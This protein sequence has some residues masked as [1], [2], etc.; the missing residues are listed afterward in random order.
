MNASND[1]KKLD[2]SHNLK[3]CACKYIYAEGTYNSL[4]QNLNKLYK[5]CKTQI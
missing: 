3:L 2:L 1:N 4:T 5:E